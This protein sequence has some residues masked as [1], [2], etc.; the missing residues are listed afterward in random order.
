MANALFIIDVQNDFP[1]SRVKMAPYGKVDMRAAYKV[2]DRLSLFA[3]AENITNARY[4]E[5]RDYGT[6]GRSYYAGMTVTW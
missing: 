5:S 2:N 4:Q 3:R 6:P 1:F